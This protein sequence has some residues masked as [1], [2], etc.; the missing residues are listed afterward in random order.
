MSADSKTKIPKQYSKAILGWREWKIT[1]DGDLFSLGFG[2]ETWDRGENSAICA[3]PY[4]DHKEIAPATD[5]ECGLYA[6]Y[7]PIL[8]PQN[9]LS[10]PQENRVQGLVI[11][12]GKAEMYSTGFRS[13]KMTVLGLVNSGNALVDQAIRKHGAPSFHSL[14]KLT[15]YV[16]SIDSDDLINYVG[17]ASSSSEGINKSVY[18]A[19][20]P[21]GNLHSV[22]DRPAIIYEDGSKEWRHH[23]LLHRE[24]DLPALT[25][26]K[27]ESQYWRKGLLYRE[28][29]LP[30]RTIQEEHGRS[31]YWYNDKNE[32]HRDGDMPA[33]EAISEPGYMWNVFNF[34]KI[35]KDTISERVD[36]R[37]WYQ[38]GDLHR[39]ERKGPAV[40]TPGHEIWIKHGRF[41][42]ESGP[43]LIGYQSELFFLND[44]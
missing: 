32:L 9:G 27:G 40:S 21:N 44:R 16:A 11:A 15:N 7:H 28:N 38:N 3:N 22:D 18:R 23:G 31:S 17:L 43:A 41:H 6:Y 5:C 25:T 14:S 33:H 36:V 26:T 39:E 30:A 13:E 42:R 8:L 20:D 12:R 35:K 34:E 4:S 10:K 19:C 37:K 2:R 1:P 24:K 29:N